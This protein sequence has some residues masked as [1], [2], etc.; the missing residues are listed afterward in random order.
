MLLASLAILGGLVL[1]AYSADRFVDAA[2]AVARALGLPPLLIGMLVVGFGT[3]APE[4]LVSVNAAWQDNPGLALGNAYGSNIMNIAVILG[5]TALLVPIA[6]HSSVV[7][8]ELPLLLAVTVLTLV[9]AYHQAMLTRLDGLIL[10]VAFVL[11]MGWSI[12]QGMNGRSDTLAMEL[13]SD[14]PPPAGRALAIQIGWVVF[15]LVL[16]VVASRLLV[17]GSVYV[18]Q[19]LGLSDL[20]IGLTIVAIGTSLPELASSL[21]AVRK[22]AHDLALGN[23]IGSNLFNTLIVAGLAVIIAPTALEPDL[24][25]RDLPVMAGLTLLLMLMAFSFRGRARRIN[26]IEGAALLGLYVAWTGWI[27]LSLG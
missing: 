12:R 23:I 7:R 6:V 20:V 15:G 22:G 21:A 24:L 9:L 17:W 25:Q 19:A 2:T 13:A 1:L 5:L 26:R 3:S 16:L 4:I 27:L 14:D 11:L 8:R 10:L 18:A